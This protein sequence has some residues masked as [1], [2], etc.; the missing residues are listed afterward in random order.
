MWNLPG[1]S[2][3][4]IS[5]TSCRKLILSAVQNPIDLAAVSQC[6]FGVFF[7][8]GQGQA[9]KIV[10]FFRETL[11]L[12]LWTGRI[13]VPL[14][15]YCHDNFA[16]KSYSVCQWKEMHFW[17]IKKKLEMLEKCTEYY[18]FFANLLILN[19]LLF[20]EIWFYLVQALCCYFC[21]YVMAI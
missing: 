21:V 3:I 8:Q 11:S 1:S 4:L 9:S 18:E 10:S 6:W 16:G 13:S 5:A 15:V 14:L 12:W 2:N 20:E 19:R 7:V 17:P